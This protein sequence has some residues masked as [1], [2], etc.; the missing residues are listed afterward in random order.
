M[1]PFQLGSNSYVAEQALKWGC[2]GR[3]ILSRDLSGP[4]GRPIAMP[5]QP[6]TDAE[7]VDALAR[8]MRGVP[9]PPSQ[10]FT[11]HDDHYTLDT[12]PS[13]LYD[14]YGGGGADSSGCVYFFSSQLNYDDWTPV[15]DSGGGSSG[16]IIGWK[17]TLVFQEGRWLPK[18]RWA[19]DEF[20]G[21]W[22]QGFQR[23][24]SWLC[25]YRLRRLDPVVQAHQWWDEWQLRF[26]VLLSLSIQCFYLPPWLKLFIWIL[27]IASDAVPINAL[28]AILDRQ[29]KAPDSTPVHGNR[30]LELLWAPI[31]LMHIGGSIAVPIRNM[32]ESEQWTK[33][34]TRTRGNWLLRF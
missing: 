25:L 32:E 14:K 4:V 1:E 11:V 13:Y 27:Y 20:K 31:L 19:M 7:L 8:R 24:L 34:L 12:D 2:L 33:H 21:E 22:Q 9:P 3:P 18:I 30:D 28:A 23:S 17:D 6:A 5:Q 15:L 26:L 10:P 29:K 16:T